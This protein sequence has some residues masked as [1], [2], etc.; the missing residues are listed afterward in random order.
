MEF[1]YPQPIM[2]SRDG[3][4]RENAFNV[5]NKIFQ[6]P[7]N[8]VKIK[9]IIPTQDEYVDCLN[10]LGCDEEF[11]EFFK[12]YNTKFFSKKNYINK[13]RITN[14]KKID[15]YGHVFFDNLYF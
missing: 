9:E 15:D 2:I 10:D 7:P 8:N 5:I 13:I 1:A 4:I 14:D 11:E 6:N 3:D 12:V